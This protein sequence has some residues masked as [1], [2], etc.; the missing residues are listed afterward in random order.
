MK[1]EY[2]SYDYWAERF[3]HE[4]P[5]TL[6]SQG[7]GAITFE[8]YVVMYFTEEFPEHGNFF[9]PDFDKYLTKEAA[10]CDT[11]MKQVLNKGIQL[12]LKQV[13]A[14]YKADP[15]GTKFLN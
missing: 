2:Y 9:H 11:A 5:I 7:L 13:E 1:T 10:K 14:M 8:Q 4:T 15:T 3:S 12:T 6:A